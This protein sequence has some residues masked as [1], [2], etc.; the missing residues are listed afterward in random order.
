LGDSRNIP[1]P[2]FNLAPAAIAKQTIGSIIPFNAAV[3]QD[4]LK[5]ATGRFEYLSARKDQ[6]GEKIRFGIFALNGASLVALM[7]TL[8]GEGSAATWL[9]FTAS[10]SAMSA[11]G[12]AVGASLA[13]AALIREA[14]RQDVEAA[15]AFARQLKL[16]QI[17]AL[18]SSEATDVNFRNL[19]ELKAEYNELPLVGFGYSKIAIALQNLACGAWLLGMTIPLV[20]ALWR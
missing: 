1:L 8:A 2:S 10:N 6:A 13:G 9:G 11:A 7:S 4:E 5:L 14:G 12:F 20:Q 15:H 16:S 18:Y 19:N 17:V 3:S